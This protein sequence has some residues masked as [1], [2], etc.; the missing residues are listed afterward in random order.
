MTDHADTLL[1]ARIAA[2]G[3]PIDDSD[4]LDVRR[5]A[6]RSRRRWLALPIAAT[7]AMLAVG[8]ALGLHRQI[9]DFLTAEPAPERV[10]VE[11]GR[12]SVSHQLLGGQLDVV[13]GEARKVTE[14]E[15]HGRRRA[16]YVAPRKDGGF[17]WSWPEL[18][19]SCAGRDNALGFSRLYSYS[20]GREQG[21]VGGHVLPAATESLEIRYEDGEREPIPFIWVSPPIDAGFFIFELQPAHLE[22]GHRPQE[23]LA[24]DRDGDELARRKFLYSDPRLETGRDG[25]PLN[26]DRSRQRT[27]FDFRDHRGKRW[28]LAVA[29]AAGDRLCWTYG[30]GGDCLSPKFPATIERMG[31]QGGAAVNVCCAVAEGVATVELRYEDGTVERLRPV[32]G[33][34]LHVIPPQH[35]A[36]GHR[37]EA[38]VWR[39]AEGREVARHAIPVDR[40]GIYPCS[41]EDEI[42][43]DY[44]QA[45]CP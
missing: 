43:L 20:G 38:I 24:L 39:D 10:V 26:A 35:Y 29:P 44:G 25:L 15:I 13:P 45:I 5:R 37:L 34:L 18:L 9:V 4:W 32:E 3:N 36:R 21:I 31:V 1:A 6:R 22:S 7:L 2:L 19:T 11:F 33:F 42:Q 40:K 12:L 28:T 23:L 17:C 30:G 41:T 27:L 8:S 14:E 16:L